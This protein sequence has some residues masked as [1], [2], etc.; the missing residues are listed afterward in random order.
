MA[1]GVKPDSERELRIFRL[2]F[3]VRVN[4]TVRT[5]AMESARTVVP[6]GKIIRAKV[7]QIDLSRVVH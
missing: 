7:T 4:N 6:R 5:H 2:F 1:L 3:R